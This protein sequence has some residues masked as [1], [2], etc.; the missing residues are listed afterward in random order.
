MTPESTLERLG[1]ALPPAWEPGATLE[2]CVRH[3]DLLYLSGHMG[4]DMSRVVTFHGRDDHHPLV[5]GRV[6]VEIELAS[7]VEIARGA[8]LNVVATLKA[9]LGQLSRVRRIVKTVAYVNAGERFA[10]VHKVAD[11]S[12]G[13]LVE[14]FGDAGRH[15]RSTIGVIGL[16]AEACFALEAIVAVD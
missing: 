1:L 16:P 14:I 10:E 9:Q 15:A 5:A 3:G 4:V 11:A 13:L 2:M 6:G 8:A 12:S 7:A